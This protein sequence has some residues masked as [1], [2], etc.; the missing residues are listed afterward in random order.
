M[1]ASKGQEHGVRMPMRMADGGWWMADGGWWMVDGRGV[2]RVRFASLL[3]WLT[4]GGQSGQ[5][6]Q[7]RCMEAQTGARP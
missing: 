2:W 6:G 1:I 5:S 3:F 7:P 4:W